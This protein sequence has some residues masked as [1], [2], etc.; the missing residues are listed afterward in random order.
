MSTEIIEATTPTVLPQPTMPAMLLLVQAVLQR[1]HEAV[2]REIR[3]DQR[4]RP[5]GVV[6]LDRDERDV[7]RLLFD[8][9][10]TSVRCIVFAF[11]TV[12]FSSGVTPSSSSPRVRMSS[13]RKTSPS[14]VSLADEVPEV[15]DLGLADAVDAAEALLQPV[16]VPGQV[17][18]DHQVGALEVDALAGRVGGDRICTSLS[19]VKAPAPCGRSSRPMP[20]WM[21]DD[22]LGPP[23]QRRGSAR[24]GSSACRG[25]R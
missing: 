7:D 11:V 8:S 13:R 23:E 16:G 25:A 19:C 18:V 21:V 9:D 5:F 4:R 15:A 1:H 3:R 12:N 6:G 22:G 20:P 10:C 17:V 2:R 14:R 24:P